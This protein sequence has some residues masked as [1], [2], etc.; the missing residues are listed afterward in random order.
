MV[1]LAAALVGFVLLV[2]GYSTVRFLRRSHSALLR[3]REEVDRAWSN[4]EVLLERRY[5][6]LGSLVDLTNEQV[7]HER[8]LL[9][10]LAAA[11][12]AA[13]EASSPGDIADAEVVIRDTLDELTPLSA[14]LPEFEASERFDDIQES[15]TEI[16][17]R[18]ES[19]R[20][21]YND[22]VARY[23]SRRRA[24]P[25]RLFAT[26]EGLERR[27]PFEASDQAR[28]GIDIRDRFDR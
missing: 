16:E 11:R 8:E 9:F 1:T 25:E 7:D 20:E 19:R 12:T 6:E 28:E 3:T 4:V 26:G 23:N 17:A 2:L 24:V 27:E 18:L 10:D 15:L 13:I 14:E 5:D 21:H 22:A